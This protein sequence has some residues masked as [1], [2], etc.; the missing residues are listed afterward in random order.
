MSVQHPTTTWEANQD[1]TSFFRRQEVYAMQWSLASLSDFIVAGARRGGPI[2]LRRNESA[3]VQYGQHTTSKPQV[4]V[5]SS[6]GALLITIPWELGKIVKMGWSYDEQLVILNEDGVY[7]VYD[8]Q[9]EYSQNSLGQEAQDSGVVDAVIHDFGMVALT[10]NLGFME[11]KGW[12]GGRPVS[13][14]PQVRVPCIFHTTTVLGHC[15]PD[16]SLS[17]HVEVLL[18]YENTILSVDSLESVDQQ[19]S[20]GP[21]Q[22]IV[23]SPSGKAIALLT[24]SGTLWVVSSNFQESYTEYDTT[25]EGMQGPPQQLVWCGNDTLVMNWEMIVVMVGPFGT[26]LKYYYTSPTHLISEIDGVRIISSDRCDFLQKVP[27]PSEMVF[28][29]GSTSAAAILFDALELFEKKSP[30]SD[31]IIR[32]IRPELA[33]AVDTCIAAAGHE[34]EPYWQKRLLNAALYGRAFLDLYNPTDLVEMGQ[35]LKVLNA[36]RYF[37]I[38]IPITYTQYIQASPHHLI[39]RLTTRNLHLLALRI[40]MYIKL[41]P[42]VVLRH[43]ASAKISQSRVEIDEETK[44]AKNDDEEVCGLIV[45]KFEALGPEASQGVSYSEIAKKAWSAGRSRLA[46]ML[47]DHEPRAG[48]QVPLLLTMNE[49]Q[50]ALT[51]AVDSGDTDLVYYVLLHLKRRLNLGDFFRLIEEGGPKLKLA[52]D[53]LQVYARQQNRELL[54]DFWFQDDRRTESATLALEEAANATGLA[55]K[56]ENIKIAAKFFSEDKQRTFEAKMMD[57][58][59]KLLAFQQQLEKDLDETKQFVGLSITETIRACIVA[60]LHKKAERLR[61]DFKVPDKRWWYTKLHALVDVKDFDGLDAFAKSKRSPIG[62]EPF[63]EYLVSQGYTKQA[64]SFV[65]KCDSKLRV[66]LYV[67][68]NEWKM[69]AQECKERG[70]KAKLQELKQLSPNN[71]VAREL[72]GVLLTMG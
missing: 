2:A 36:V 21:F 26:V 35:A 60:G 37:E 13:L 3:I 61:N 48:D 57:E 64:A 30:R 15:S 31:E 38:G 67:K 44:R 49:D 72:D 52:A 68:C 50:L 63:V 32:S 46:T 4:Q 45:A 66:D 8:L 39:N 71:V 59:L 47:L 27:R 6:S 53:L 9:G 5:F 34:L 1:G 69:A 42:D 62:Y 29:P 20:R 16:Q 14:A 33:G 17:R 56:I 11:V 55:A 7:R 65:P 18:P 10:G 28:K 24:V 22:H 12:E 54:R 51:K 58:Y 70:D 19:I 43:W 40:S 23:I 25:T 41:K